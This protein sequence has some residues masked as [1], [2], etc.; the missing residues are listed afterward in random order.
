VQAGSLT[1]AG[2]RSLPSTRQFITKAAA[3]MA[4]TISNNIMEVRNVRRYINLLAPF[5]FHNFRSIVRIM[6]R[7]PI[8]MDAKITPI[9]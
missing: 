1:L 9:P 4:G 5:F 8:S 6:R 3:I 7:V 2:V